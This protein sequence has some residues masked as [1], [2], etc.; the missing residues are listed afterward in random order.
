MIR[1]R[2]SIALRASLFL[3][4]LSTVML[5]CVAL[6]M[7]RLGGDDDGT[8]GAND[9]ADQIKKAVARETDGK[10]V[11]RSTDTLK[12]TAADF[13]SF[14]YIVSDNASRI[15]F[16]PVPEK[17]LRALSEAH[18]GQEH[19]KTSNFIAYSFE[20][21]R[22]QL[23][24]LTT[25]KDTDVGQITIETGGVAYTAAQMTWGTITDAA[26]MSTP[27]LIVLV[28]TTFVGLV[29]VPPLIARPVRRTASAIEMIGGADKQMRVPDE[30]APRELRPIIRSFN[31][32]LDRIESIS[33]AQRRF[34]SNA[35]HELR[36]PLT[37][38]RMRLDDIRDEKLR[39]ILVSDVQKLS[40][41][42]TML[43]QLARISNEPAQLAQ[44]D[45]V[46]LTRAVTAE[47]VPA[48]LRQGRELVFAAPEHAVL[49]TGAAQAISVAVSNLIRNALLHSK[50]E[51]PVTVEVRAPAT[52]IVTDHGVGIAENRRKEVLEPF[53]KGH[54]SPDGTGL[55]LSI[56]A[57]VM[58]LHQGDLVVSETPGGGTT[59]SL[60]FAKAAAMIVAEP[61]DR[62]KSQDTG[63]TAEHQQQPATG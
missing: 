60:H 21:D 33:S 38:V 39:A 19:S 25:Q 52:I 46:V 4:A 43:L 63:K 61:A 53:V 24:R 31:N 41:T 54:P 8:W 2:N 1:S 29:V 51:E 45:L 30:T 12:K 62:A 42:V 14:W 16:G 17:R 11:V 23:K 55:G 32:A 10:L 26:A 48:A 18:E 47:Q 20:G 3:G 35:A 7:L 28:V 13:P 58:A 49:V 50:T 27:I 6:L 15:V 5:L 22:K 59:V 56:V 37:K 34:L 40:S 9:V 36:T 44:V 57:Q